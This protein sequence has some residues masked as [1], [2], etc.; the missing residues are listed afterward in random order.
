MKLTV[1]K[2]KNSIWVS[3]YQTFGIS[4]LRTIGPSDYRTFGL[5]DL[6]TIGPSDYRTVTTIAITDSLRFQSF[7]FHVF[8]I[9]LL[10]H[11]TQRVIWAFAISWGPSI[12]CKLLIWHQIINSNLTW[13]ILR[14]F[15]LKKNM[16]D[17]I[18]LHPTRTHPKNQ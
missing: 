14:S 4:D 2:K 6:R 17:D 7:M 12:V 1:K 5:S 18:T 10:T 11:P 9:E 13:M 16:S 8:F 15:L 3:D